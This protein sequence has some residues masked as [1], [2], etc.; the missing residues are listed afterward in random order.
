[1]AALLFRNKT[2]EILAKII[3]EEEENMSARGG[4]HNMHALKGLVQFRARKNT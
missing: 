2:F 3:V 4:K 1:M